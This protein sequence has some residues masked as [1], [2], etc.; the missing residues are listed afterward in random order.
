MTCEFS[1]HF[2]FLLLIFSP[3]LV[4]RHG[5]RTRVLCESVAGKGWDL[6]NVSGG[7]EPEC[8]FS[9]GFLRWV[10]KYWGLVGW[11][12]ARAWRETLWCDGLMLF[13]WFQHLRSTEIPYRYAIVGV[14]IKLSFMPLCSRSECKTRETS[15][16]KI[17][18]YHNKGSHLKTAACQHPKALVPVSCNSLSSACL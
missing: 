10:M 13:C 17:A 7:V 3:R 11:F 2:F 15:I 5:Y 14:V 16:H 6:T 12:T 1:H 4:F 9:C 8:A 18:I